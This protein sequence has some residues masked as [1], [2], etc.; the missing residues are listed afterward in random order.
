MTILTPEQMLHYARRHDL[1]TF[2]R[3]CFRL[4]LPGEVFVPNWHVDAICHELERVLAGEVK[5][6][7]ICVPPRSLKSLCASVA[8]PAFAL[9]RDPTRK[10]ITASYADPL[11][12]KLARDCHRVMASRDYKDL[13]P[14]TRIDP[15]KDSQAEFA[16]TR[17]GFRLATSIGGTLT[18][19]GGSLLIVDDP[20]KAQDAHSKAGRAFVNERFAGALLSRLDNKETGAV[21]VVMQRL[22]VDDL[23]GHLLGIGGWE[24]LSLPAIAE[25]EAFIPIG[26]GRVHHRK[27]GD[28]L[29]PAREPQAALER[30]KRELGLLDFAAQYQQAPV[31]PEGNLIRREWLRFYAQAPERRSGDTVLISWDTAMKTS[32]SADYSVATVWL[33]RDEE[34][35]LLDLVRARF[36]FPDLLTAALALHRRWNPIATVVEDKNSGT[37]LIQ[38][39]RREG[40]SVLPF[41]PTVEKEARMH[42]QSVRFATGT[43]SLPQ[44]AAWLED[45][46]EELLAFPGGRHDDQVDS[47]SQ[48]LEWAE[49]ERQRPRM[50]I[51][52]L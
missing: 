36:D 16:T 18:G 37:S 26:A 29:F 33:I 17:G 13:F 9:G 11:A 35:Y 39:M 27:P 40:L 25:E 20:M 21:I 52:Q 45:L 10:I 7:I 1:S 49:Q 5:R 48:A 50:R 30:V 12:Y 34:H 3:L 22:H 31:P 14:D 24:V 23:V 38:A 4:L 51:R 15:T 46:V 28:P 44:A 8:L 41:L 47:V 19:R 6:L 43:V 32:A 2:V 42:A